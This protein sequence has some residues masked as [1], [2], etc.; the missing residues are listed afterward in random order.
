[1]EPHDLYRLNLL[2][3]PEIDDRHLLQA[4]NPVQLKFFKGSP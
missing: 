3:L 2:N 4:E 1:V